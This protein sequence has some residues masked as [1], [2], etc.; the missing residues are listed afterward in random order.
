VNIFEEYKA[1]AMKMESQMSHLFKAVP[2][3]PEAKKLQAEKQLV[4]FYVSGHPIEKWWPLAKDFVHGDLTWIKEQ[5][6]R[7][8]AG[9]VQVPK[10]AAEGPRAKWMEPTARWDVTTLALVGSFREIMTK[11]GSKMAFLEIEDAKTK[12][13]AVCF[14]DAY[15]QGQAAIRQS[16]D[17]CLPFIITGNVSLDEETAKIFIRSFDMVSEY[18]KKR[19]Q[20]VVLRLDPANV[21]THRL[22][23][24]RAILVRHRGKCNT[25][26]EYKGSISGNSFASRHSLPKELFVN[27]SAEMAQEVNALFGSDVV[28][29]V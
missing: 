17:E 12:I 24:L 4:G 20:S 10:V 1:E 3:W 26:L 22:A 2:D 16:I 6:E 7:I 25:F 23:Q 29:F 13:E 18:Q 27:P 14:P 28:K 19:V 8:K 11:K 5:Y 9:E 15:E 21:D